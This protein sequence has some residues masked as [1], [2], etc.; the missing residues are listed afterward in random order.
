[1]NGNSGSL[2]MSPDFTLS[3]AADKLCE[4]EH[5]IYPHF[6]FPCIKLWTSLQTCPW[7][8]CS[9]QVL[10]IVAGVTLMAHVQFA[11]MNTGPWFPASLFVPG[12][13]CWAVP[14]GRCLLGDACLHPWG[15]LCTAVCS[16]HII[17]G[18]NCIFCHI[19]L[20]AQWYIFT[21]WMWMTINGMNI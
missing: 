13:A 9:T 18:G 4:S 10:V 20:H 6:I 5:F 15:N 14:A 11:Q 2:Y 21:L 3:S 12:S 19:P 8:E 17:A 16:C 7:A 1:M